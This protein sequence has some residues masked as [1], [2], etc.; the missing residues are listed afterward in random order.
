VVRDLEE[1]L[2]HALLA[3]EQ[4]SVIAER[5]RGELED[6]QIARVEQRAREWPDAAPPP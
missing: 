1:A 4:G 2:L 6:V 5:C 3:G